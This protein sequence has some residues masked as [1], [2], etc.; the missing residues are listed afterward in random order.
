MMPL[1]A[2]KAE[3]PVLAARTMLTRCSTAR[4]GYIAR[5]CAG[6]L[7]RP[8]HASFVMFTI[9]SAPSLTNCLNRSGKMPS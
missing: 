9:S 2:M 4:N 3:T 6:P 1:G 8:N 7:V 5:C